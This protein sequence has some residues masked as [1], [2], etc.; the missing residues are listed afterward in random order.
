MKTFCYII[1]YVCAIWAFIT[2][3]VAVF[4]VGDTYFGMMQATFLMVVSI[5]IRM[6]AKGDDD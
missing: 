6:W 4:P 1:S 2:Y 5:A 3:F